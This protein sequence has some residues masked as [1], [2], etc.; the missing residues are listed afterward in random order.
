MS[1][2]NIYGKLAKA[3]AEFHALELKKTGH[4]TFAGYKYFELADFLVPGMTVLRENGLVPVITF[5]DTAAEMTIYEIEGDG[6]IVITSPMRDA[7]LKGCHPIQNL[8]AVETYQ[9]RYLWVAALQIVEHDAVDSAPPVEVN[10]AP[11]TKDQAANLRDELEAV[12]GDEAAFC[13]YLKVGKLEDLPARSLET[14]RAAIN[15]KRSAS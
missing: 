7:N 8:G 11:V 5:S 13:K 6:R 3:R 9:S 15:K 1:K 10:N 14:A 12:G 4:N 2:S